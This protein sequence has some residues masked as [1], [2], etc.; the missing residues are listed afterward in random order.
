MRTLS[1]VLIFLV[2]LSACDS[3]KKPSI[4]EITSEE[5]A[6]STASETIIDPEL[7]A[8]ILQQIPSPLEIS[9]LLQRSGTKYD[10]SLLNNPDNTS[11]YNSNYQKAINLGIYGTDLGYTNI[12][13]QNQDGLEF[14]SAISTLA[15]GLSIGQ[16]FELATI[17]R[18]ATNS[19]N[20]DSLLLITT[21]NFNNINAHLQEQDRSNLSV[22]LLVGGWLE[23]LHVTCQV[24]AKDPSNQELIDVIGEQKIILEQLELL[25]SFY[26]TKNPNMKDLHE[27]FLR[28]KTAYDEIEI[29][30]IPGE[31]VSKVVDG[32]LIIENT[33]RSEVKI[34]QENV[35]NITSIVEEIRTKA[36]N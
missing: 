32:V 10:G 31:P 16:F 3:G 33:D 4:E 6:D 27:S 14:M 30:I 19:K 5:E 34:T 22:L 13:E 25:L 1:F 18:L 20:L 7:I 17:G 9:V 35:D 26:S 11:K 29:T 8:A 2:V 15:E 24:S 36:I 23:A 21:Q 28:L 12:Y